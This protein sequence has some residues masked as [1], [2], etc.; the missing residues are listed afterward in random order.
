MDCSDHD[1]P[2]RELAE[3]L[4][5]VIARWEGRARAALSPADRQL[6]IA[7]ALHLLTTRFPRS[8]EPLLLLLE[9]MPAGPYRLPR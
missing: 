7:E 5:A 9:D 8:R 2:A 1:P 4:G 6:Q 3:R